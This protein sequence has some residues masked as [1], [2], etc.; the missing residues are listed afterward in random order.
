[1]SGQGVMTRPSTTGRAGGRLGTGRVR[2]GAV[3]AALFLAGV[4]ASACDP[5]A[6]PEPGWTT[7]ALGGVPGHVALTFDDGPHPVFTP[8]IL[9]ILDRYGVKG[10]FFVTGSNVARYPDLARAIVN[11]GHSIANHSW[12]H[13]KLTGITPQAV[14]RQLES[15]SRIIRDTTGYVVSC[16]RPPYGA[17]NRTV[18]NIIA[19]LDMRPALWSVDTNDWRRPGVGAIVAAGAQAPPDSV[20]L[21]HDGPNDRSQTVASLP[22]IIETLQARGLGITRVCDSR[23]VAAS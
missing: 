21:F 19:S 5:P 8:Q 17:T 6:T 4:V 7:G 10:T 12:D 14:V 22:R 3:L 20:V 11:R 13:P 18:N 9:D 16:T 2:R 23:P 1:M 15:T